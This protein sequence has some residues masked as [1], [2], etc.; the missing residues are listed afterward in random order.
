MNHES[1]FWYKQDSGLGL[2][3]IYYSINIDYINKGDVSDG[4]SVSRKEKK[5]PFL[6]TLESPPNQPD[7]LV[8]LCQQVITALHSPLLSTRKRQPHGREASNLR[9]PHASQ[10]NVTSFPT[11]DSHG[12]PLQALSLRPSQ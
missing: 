12:S 3:L 9:R 7:L 1:R 10:E 8:P 11:A 5:K 2:K 6:L 4:Y